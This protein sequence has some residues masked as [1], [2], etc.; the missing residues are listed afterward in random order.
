MDKKLQQTS[1]S[2][3]ELWGGIECTINRINDS[4]LDQLEYARHYKRE[5]DISLI[6]SLGI[7]TL[8]YPILW[9]RHQ[10]ELNTEIDWGWTEKQLSVLTHHGITPIAG[11]VHHGSGPAYTNLLDENFAEGLANYAEKV[12]TKFPWI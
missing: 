10:P 5:G 1:S 7:K 8:R 2:N 3:L 12:A 9:E 6:A 4:Y 11:L